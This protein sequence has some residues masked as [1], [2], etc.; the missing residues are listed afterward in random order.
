MSNQSIAVLPIDLTELIKLLKKETVD[1]V[2]EKL[3]EEFY[4]HAWEK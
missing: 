4:R 3:V 1:T 2:A